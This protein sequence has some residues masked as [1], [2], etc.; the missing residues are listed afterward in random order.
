MQ[1][2]CH[3][4][5]L[6]KWDSTHFFPEPMLLTK[7]TVE[8]MI[9]WNNH[10]LISLTL[11][12]ALRISNYSKVFSGSIISNL[13]AGLFPLKMNEQKKVNFRLVLSSFLKTNTTYIPIKCQVLPNNMHYFLQCSQLWWGE[14]ESSGPTF[15]CKCLL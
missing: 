10:G 15:Q 1:K 6:R 2:E 11:W 7:S 3:C 13:A 14:V 9:T 12:R 4:T 5:Q 8:A